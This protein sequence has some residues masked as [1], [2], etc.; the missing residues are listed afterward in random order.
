MPTIA[1]RQAGRH[2]HVSQRMPNQR[3]QLVVTYAALSLLIIPLERAPKSPAK[4]RAPMTAYTIVP[5]MIYSGCCL[6]RWYFR[7]CGGASH[8]DLQAKYLAIT[9]KQ[10]EGG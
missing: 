6:S 2:Q 8:A 7:L 9:A 3:G 10:R 5:V 4:A 1:G